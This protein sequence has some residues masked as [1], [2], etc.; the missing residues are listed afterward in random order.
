MSDYSPNDHLPYV[1]L[2]LVISVAIVFIILIIS[3]AL[4]GTDGLPEDQDPK[5]LLQDVFS[6]HSFLDQSMYVAVNPTDTE[7]KVIL[8][9]STLIPCD[10]YRWVYNQTDQTLEWG[11][12]SSSVPDNEKL[13]I[14]VDL[15]PGTII[16]LKPK[17]TPSSINQWVFNQ[18]NNTWC[19]KSTP[20]LCMNSTGNILT[21]ESL[22]SEDLGF[23]WVISRD[24]VP[25]ACA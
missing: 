20:T 6:F 21:L 4:T 25:P 17:G 2:M 8:S 18:N 11:G 14:T 13:V 19:L 9:N 12:N 3:R 16:V 5:A 10:S 1:M 24:L 15:N 23:I 22:V 7:D